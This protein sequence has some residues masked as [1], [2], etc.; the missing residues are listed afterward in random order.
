MIEIR[1]WLDWS[2]EEVRLLEINGVANFDRDP[3]KQY[4]YNYDYNML[5][6]VTVDEE[7]E[8]VVVKQIEEVELL[9]Y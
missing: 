7:S 2:Y 5:P 8:E 6:L 3:I 4:T 9:E 1:I